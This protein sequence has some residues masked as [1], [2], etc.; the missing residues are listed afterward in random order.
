ML[1]EHSSITLHPNIE[2]DCVYVAALGQA[3]GAAGASEARMRLLL[4]QLS[5]NANPFAQLRLLE[6]KC[7]SH[8]RRKVVG[9]T[10]G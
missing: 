9:A 7:Y 3:V 5:P 4:K 8:L 1:A 2:A 10:I 6:P